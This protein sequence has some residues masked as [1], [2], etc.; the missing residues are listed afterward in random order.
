MNSWVKFPFD[1]SSVEWEAFLSLGSL[2]TSLAYV[3]VIVLAR[4]FLIRHVRR[5]DEILGK[6][7]RSWIIRIKNTAGILMVVGLIMIWAPQLHT[8]ALSITAFAVAL[9]VATKEMILCLTGAIMRATS[10]QFKVGD[11]VT[12]DNVTGEVIDMDPLSFR[13]QE[14]DMEGKTYHFT[15]Q[16]IT[17]PNAKLFTS[18]VV[19]ANFFKAYIFED[20]RVTVQYMDIDPDAAMGVLQD[21]VD[22][23]FE[24]H[25]KD[26][27]AFNKKIRKKEGI[28][29]GTAQPLYDLTTSDFGHYRFHV[30]L[31]LPT[32][33][34]VNIGSD[35][36]RDFLGK[37]HIMRERAM[38]ENKEAAEP[39][40]AQA[41][42]KG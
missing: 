3:A 34:A 15:G 24:P 27:L 23:Y 12:V 9:V 26:A 10:N 28:E 39:D 41:G 11:W 2:I 5:D 16:T 37:I 29:I 38:N 6:E 20:V 42:S 8:F 40:D 36:S 33:Q 14:V 1:L 13:L 21:V 32:A 30:R 17:V 18:N 19:N 35:I 4:G 22:T 25:K 7:Q 31:F